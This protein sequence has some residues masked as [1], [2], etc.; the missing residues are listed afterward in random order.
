MEMSAL[1]KTVECGRQGPSRAA[2]GCSAIAMPSAA[3]E[4]LPVRRVLVLALSIIATRQMLRPPQGRESQPK[5][6]AMKHPAAL[7]GLAR[8]AGA[9]VSSGQA[10][11]AALLGFEASERSSSRRRLPVQTAQDRSTLRSVHSTK[12]ARL[13]QRQTHI[14]GARARARDYDRWGVEQS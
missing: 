8:T 13:D 5:P 7:A 6:T 1:V 2:A 4:R 3:S 12:P 10:R 11:A 9:M 14:R